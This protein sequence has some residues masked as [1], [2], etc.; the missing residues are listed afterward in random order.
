MPRPCRRRG[1]VVG[2]AYSARGRPE[3]HLPGARDYTLGND[4]VGGTAVATGDILDNL[5][6][7]QGGRNYSDGCTYKGTIVSQYGSPQ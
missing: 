1:N 6:N 4:P 7:W 5:Q 3:R 2:S